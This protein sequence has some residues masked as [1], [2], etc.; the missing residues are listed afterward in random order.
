MFRTTS[1]FTT[2][3]AAA[4]LTCQVLGSLHLLCT[5]HRGPF[6]E[7]ALVAE[8]V[9]GTTDDR[10]VIEASLPGEGEEPCECHCSDH[11]VP[12]VAARTLIVRDSQA[13]DL[14]AAHADAAVAILATAADVRPGD[15]LPLLHPPSR[16]LRLLLCALRI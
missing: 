10:G 11:E 9:L 15:P 4:A 12:V 14:A 2:L 6:G 5:C 7:P 13:I 16:P 8:V 3:F 1:T